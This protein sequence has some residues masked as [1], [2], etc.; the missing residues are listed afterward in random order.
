MSEID[1]TYDD[2]RICGGGWNSDAEYCRPPYLYGYRPGDRSGNLGFRL[3]EKN[4]TVFDYISGGSW[5]NNNCNCQSSIRCRYDDDSKSRDVSFR[6][7][8]E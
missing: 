3:I 7:I 1:R 5:A 8:E 2:W 6:L 4:Q